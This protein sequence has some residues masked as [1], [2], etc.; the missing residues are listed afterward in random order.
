MY[1][2]WIAVTMFSLNLIAPR[3]NQ[4]LQVWRTV[5]LPIDAIEQFVLE[6][7]ALQVLP[8]IGNMLT[9]LMLTNGTLRSD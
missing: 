8:V 5:F 4:G 1:C 6:V 3:Q 7:S 9:S 2:F